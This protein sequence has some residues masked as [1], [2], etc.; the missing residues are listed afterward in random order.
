MRDGSRHLRLQWEASQPGAPAAATAAYEK[1]AKAFG[2]I[3]HEMRVAGA[4]EYNADPYMGYTLSALLVIHHCSNHPEIVQLAQEILDTHLQVYLAGV[5]E[6]KYVGPFRRRF[7]RARKLNLAAH[8]GLAMLAVWQARRWG[9]ELDTNRTNVA[10]HQALMAAVCRYQ[11]P[12]SL[13][14]QLDSPRLGSY[15][16]GHGPKAAPGQYTHGGSWLLAGGGAYR[17]RIAQSVPQ[18][19]V[20]LTQH[21]SPNLRDYVHLP[22]PSKGLRVNHTG[23]WQHVAIGPRP[24]HIPPTAE[25]LDSLGAWLLLRLPGENPVFAAVH[26]PKKLGAIVVAQTDRPIRSWFQA[27]AEANPKLG[28]KG[29]LRLPEGQKLVYDTGSCRSR[30]AIWPSD[31][32]RNARKF[33][34]WPQWQFTPLGLD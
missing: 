29:R 9:T 13:L 4:F 33:D 31:T 1:H 26:R 20:L 8:P 27:L 12:D 2:A 21:T 7:E 32:Q 15:T 5:F 10:R 30:W 14:A 18:P 3:L 22:L 34:R 16:L 24:P 25:R 17:G 23:I 6:N 28:S 11:P 19:I